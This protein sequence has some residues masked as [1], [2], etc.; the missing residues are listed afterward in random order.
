MDFVIEGMAAIVAAT[1][2]ARTKSDRRRTGTGTMGA[3]IPV[4]SMSQTKIIPR[5]PQFFSGFA[6]SV[7]DDLQVITLTFFRMFSSKNTH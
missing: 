5:S 4:S 2:R 1:Q 6:R 3:L 7:R